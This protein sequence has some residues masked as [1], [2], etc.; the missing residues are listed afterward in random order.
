MSRAPGALALVGSG[1]YTAA[2]RTTDEIL[3]GTLQPDDGVVVIPTASA[4]EPGQPERWNSLGV[5]HFHELGARV[6]PLLLLHRT[7]ALSPEIA[8][9][10]KEQHFFYF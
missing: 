9:L 4:L 2:M 6:T 3:L 7:D 10:L 1:E 8:A 5:A